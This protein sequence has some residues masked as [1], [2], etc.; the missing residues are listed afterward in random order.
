MPFTGVAGIRTV[1]CA[2]YSKYRA[3]LVV[4]VSHLTIYQPLGHLATVQHTGPPRKRTAHGALVCGYQDTPAAH[5]DKTICQP[6]TWT[7]IQ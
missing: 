3:S 1:E 7:T 6:L 5:Q 2:V 4:V